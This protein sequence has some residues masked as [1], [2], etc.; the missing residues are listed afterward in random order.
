MNEKKILDL[1][2]LTDEAFDVAKNCV[3]AWQNDGAPLGLTYCN[4]EAIQERNKAVQS[5]CSNAY[6]DG[7]LWAGIAVVSAWVIN[8]GI[9]FVANAIA[10][11]IKEKQS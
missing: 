5:A 11:K 4:T 3:D 9:D 7:F 2:N 1:S 6:W 10:A 8:K